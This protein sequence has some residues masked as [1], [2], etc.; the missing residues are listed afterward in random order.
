MTDSSP[1]FYLKSSLQVPIIHMKSEDQQN[2]TVFAWI[3]WLHAHLFFIDLEKRVQTPALWGPAVLQSD[4]GEKLQRK[5]FFLKLCFNDALGV[6]RTNSTGDSSRNV[7]FSHIYANC[8]DDCD[9][10]KSLV[11]KDGNSKRT[12]THFWWFYTCAASNKTEQV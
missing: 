5:H 7:C 11:A 12:L 6:I 2:I 4:S 9:G 3:L 10:F 1:W 8:D